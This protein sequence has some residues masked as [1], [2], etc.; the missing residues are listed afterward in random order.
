MEFI[1]LFIVFNFYLFFFK[2]DLQH[3]QT[4]F[5]KIMID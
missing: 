2:E 3:A 4:H 5:N 1:F